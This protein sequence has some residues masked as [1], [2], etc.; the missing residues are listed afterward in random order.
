MGSMLAE[1]N[2]PGL[3]S[4]EPPVT[5]VI[6]VAS[7]LRQSHAARGLRY[8]SLDLDDT[9]EADIL[10]LLPR[11]CRAIDAAIEEGGNAFVH[12]AAGVS[13]S[14]AMVVG[15]CMWKRGWG[16]GEAL[17][18]VRAQRDIVSPNPGFLCQLHLFDTLYGRD[19]GAEIRAW[20]HHYRQCVEDGTLGRLHDQY[21]RW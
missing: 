8:L 1:M 9:E 16:L 19:I 13:R 14:G 2:F 7:G 10:S 18:H 17:R 21:K 15:Y 5:H 4:M 11:V 3:A 6:Q 12:C 20:R